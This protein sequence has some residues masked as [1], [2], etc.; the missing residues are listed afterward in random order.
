MFSRSWNMPHLKFECSLR[1]KH[2][3][4][5][6]THCAV[7]KQAIGND[8]AD[9][10]Y[11]LHI[12]F[13][14]KYFSLY[15]TGLRSGKVAS[16]SWNTY[17]GLRIGAFGMRVLSVDAQVV[18]WTLSVWSLCTRRDVQSLCNRFSVDTWGRVLCQFDCTLWI[19]TWH[20]CLSAEWKFHTEA[21]NQ[22]M[23]RPGCVIWEWLEFDA[24]FR[25][26]C[27]Q[28]GMRSLFQNKTVVLLDIIM[29]G[30]SGAS[31]LLS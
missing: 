29:M 2:L 5:N 9:Y 19:D 1:F 10:K 3:I 16:L 13:E 20:S 17:V 30:A 23:T 18:G 21:A 22:W 14:N 27:S 25:T 6:A 26:K 11:H 15:N 24:E 8:F 12:F 7:M 4:T 28:L 31:S